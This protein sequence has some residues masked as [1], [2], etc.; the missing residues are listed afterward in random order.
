MPLQPNRGE[1]PQGGSASSPLS[2]NFNFGQLNTMMDRLN[3][4]LNNDLMRQMYNMQANTPNFS[5]TQ[6]ANPEQ[7][8]QQNRN[9]PIQIWENNQQ[10]YVLA[11]LPGLKN[12]EDVKVTFLDDKRI[13]LR[14]KANT[15]RPERNS[16][17]VQ[18]EFPKSVIER[19]IELPQPV[20]TTSYSANYQDGLYTLTLHKLDE[21]YEIPFDE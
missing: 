14:A 1:S 16:R 10:I 4:F 21:E 13:R 5:N 18:S 6:H 20:S 3:M 19:D 8:V 15:N 11:S 9:V 2:P 12:S 7:K 17:M